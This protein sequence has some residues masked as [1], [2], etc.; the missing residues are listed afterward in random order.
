MKVILSNLKLMSTQK[1][2]S[3]IFTK[4]GGMGCMMM[5]T[6]IL[7]NIEPPFFNFEYYD[8]DWHGEDFYF[9]NK[10]RQAGHKILIDMNLSFQVRHVGQW[11]FGPSIGTNEEKRVDNEVKKITKMK[12]VRKNA[13]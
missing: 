10:L 1:I 5:K 4:G 6:E 13:E 8:N 7:K 9:Q 2:P 11:A 12:K 3:I